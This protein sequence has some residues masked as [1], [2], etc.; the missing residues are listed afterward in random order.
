MNKVL[1]NLADSLHRNAVSLFDCKWMIS[2]LQFDKGAYAD[3]P[4]VDMR[5]QIQ[6]I[7]IGRQRCGQPTE[8]G[9]FLLSSALMPQFAGP[10]VVRFAKRDPDCPLEDP[11]HIYQP[12]VDIS[13]DV[14]ISPIDFALIA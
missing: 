3:W 10:V 8:I 4:G 11:R 2:W 9:W 7:R 5:L 6:S 1:S 14:E 13:N 12:N